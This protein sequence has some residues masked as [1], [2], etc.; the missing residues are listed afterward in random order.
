MAA[1]LTRKASTPAIATAIQL[2]VTLILLWIGSVESIILYAGVGLSIFSML[3]MSSI[4]VLRRTRPDLP[5]PFRTPGYPVTPA[6]Y[7]VLTG[8]MTL[9]AFARRPKVSSYALLSIL[10]G[11]PFY[12]LW[13]MIGGRKP[14]VERSLE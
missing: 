14:A 2:A 7:L 6:L 4:F 9:A 1:R 3:A 12:Y 8:I 13:Q 5:R 10:A 11:V